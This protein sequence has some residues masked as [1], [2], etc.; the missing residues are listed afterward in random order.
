MEIKMIVELNVQRKGDTIIVGD[1]GTLN[2]IMGT[3]SAGAN[4]HL[5]NI[6]KEK[7]KWYVPVS[8]VKERMELLKKRIERC[9]GSLKLMK[10]ITK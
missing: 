3:H 9:E 7:G 1:L 10:Q 5:Y 6:K 4:I 8:E 2:A